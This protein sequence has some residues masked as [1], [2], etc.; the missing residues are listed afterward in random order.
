MFQ[1]QPP[2]CF[3]L[4]ADPTFQADAARDLTYVSDS[5]RD[6]MKEFPLVGMILTGSV[7][8]GEGTLI[9]DSAG[10]TRW[11]GNIE[12]LLLTQDRKTAIKR[13]DSELCR[14][15]N[16]L[17]FELRKQGRGL[18]VG[19]TCM[20]AQQLSRLR[21]SIFNR[22]LLEHGKLLWG[23]PSALPLPSWWRNGQRDIPQEDGLRLLNNRIIEQLTARA[24]HDISHQTVTAA[25]Y[26]IGKF[27]I[28]LATSLSVFLGCYRSTYRERQAEIESLFGSRPHLFDSPFQ[29]LLI[30]RLRQAMAL[31]LGQTPPT[32]ESVDER[33]DEVARAACRIWFWATGRMLGAET[34]QSDW[35]LVPERLRR[36]ETFGQRARDW[37]RLMLRGV[38]RGETAK[39]IKSLLKA[40]LRAGSLANAIYA[41]GCLLEFFWHEISLESPPGPEITRTVSNFLGTA[42]SSQKLQRLE[43]ARAS[44]EA[45]NRH[46]RFASL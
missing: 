2:G 39:G 29:T 44:E 26:A 22:E 33:F 18:E 4:C 19:L 21:P 24:K 23:Q 30:D 41:S 43:L 27:W 5:V 34:H 25:E 14:V 37:T 32:G 42:A 12:C 16:A 11:L 35:H 6:A 15:R 8:R 40:A 10:G 46:L 3:P 7:A 28:E 1:L 20:P 45:W 13:I 31:K 17:N 9:A 38:R 36:I